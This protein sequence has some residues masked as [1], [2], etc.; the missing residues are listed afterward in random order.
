MGLRTYAIEKPG[1]GEQAH[2]RRRRYLNVGLDSHS[3][4]FGDAEDGS[5][6]RSK[7]NYMKS[8]ILG[9]GIGSEEA[10]ERS[11]NDSQSGEHG[12]EPD[13]NGNANG[14]GTAEPEEGDQHT[15]T[16]TEVDEQ[17]QQGETETDAGSVVAEPETETDAGN[18]S[19]NV[20]TETEGS[21]RAV[22]GTARDDGGNPVT[23][24]GYRE[25]SME[26]PHRR[27]QFGNRQNARSGFW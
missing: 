17:S 10:Y 9:T 14:H 22:T 6:F 15:E 24:A 7:P 1:D 11:F 16:G 23:G 4:L 12:L 21:P 3:R 20:S 5:M 8:D 2:V 13:S 25:V 27:R 26:I 19:L 18:T